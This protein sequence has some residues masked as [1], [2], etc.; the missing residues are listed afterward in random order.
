MASFGNSTASGR[1]D[2]GVLRTGGR[3]GRQRTQIENHDFPVTAVSG[4]NYCSGG[5]CLGYTYS[6]KEAI[7]DHEAFKN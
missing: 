5:L 4:N 2:E 7:Q 6:S 3:R 1:V